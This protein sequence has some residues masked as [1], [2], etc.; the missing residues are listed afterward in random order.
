MCC[1]K[2]YN[3]RNKTFFFFG[4]NKIIEKISN[5]Q[6]FGTVPTDAMKNGD[7]SFGGLGS[8]IT[9]RPRPVNFGRHMD[10]QSIPE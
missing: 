5:F 2:L 9:I 7:F 3:G 8:P 1:P 10:A 4:W 6:A